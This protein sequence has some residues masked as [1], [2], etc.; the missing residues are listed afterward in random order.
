MGVATGTTTGSH[1]LHS[2]VVDTFDPTGTQAVGPTLQSQL[3][4]VAK[5]METLQN[6]QVDF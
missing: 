5:S 4:S 1:S 3:E 6:L 2:T